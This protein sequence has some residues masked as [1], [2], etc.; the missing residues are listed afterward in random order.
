[1]RNPKGRFVR[2]TALVGAVAAP[3]V[4]LAA[5][6]LSPGRGLAVGAPSQARTGSAAAVVSPS[7]TGPCTS[8]TTTTVASTT[9]TSTPCEPTTTTSTTTAPPTTTTTT[10]PPPVSPPTSPDTPIPVTA[11]AT[12]P[13]SPAGGGGSTGTD[14]NGTPTLP[15]T[16]PVSGAAPPTTVPP[17]PGVACQQATT[18]TFTNDLAYQP[19]KKMTEGE[20]TQITVVIGNGRLPANAISGPE[21]TVII[22]VRTTCQ[23][24]VQLVGTAFQIAPSGWQS[25]TFGDPTRTTDAPLTWTWQVTPQTSGH[26]SLELQVKSD[27]EEGTGVTLQGA[28]KD[29]YANIL[30]TSD[31]VPWYH[32]IWGFLNTPLFVLLVTLAVGGG[33]VATLMDRRRKHHQPLKLDPP[34]PDA[35]A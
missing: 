28:L 19:R 33:G 7:D 31:P 11:G 22:Q 34:D 15:M 2:R 5:L 32:P 6:T 25:E 21:P 4:L 14:G 18:Q 17:S 20:P 9:T 26:D 29:Y 8:T 3:L 12:S 1:M 10:S 30:V 23:V 27:W 16:G 13:P 24:E 35:A